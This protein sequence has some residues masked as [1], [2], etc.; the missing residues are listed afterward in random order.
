MSMRFSIIIPV[1]KVEKFLHQCVDSVLVQTFS[2]YEVILVDDGSP[3]GCPG[4]CDEYAVKFPQIRVIHKLNGGLSDAR[5]AGLDVAEG[6]YIIFLDSDDWWDDKYAL[7]KID[8]RI[9]LSGVEILIIGMKKYYHNDDKFGEIRTPRQYNAEISILSNA[10]ILQLYMHSNIF[11]ACAWDK[12]VRRSLIENDHQRFVKGQMSED[13]EWCAKLLMKN[14]K[15]GILEDAFYVYRQQVSTSI[16]ANVGL[17]NI[18]SILDIISRYSKL[19]T[20]VPLLHFMANQYVLLITNFMRLNKKDQKLLNDD[21]KRYWWLLKY[22]WYPY[23]KKVSRV[24]FL[25]YEIT[26]RLLRIYYKQRHRL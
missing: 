7:K 23:T 9:K 22:N 21:V 8:D 16:T 4:I 2:D 5:N 15:I 14:S 10:Q 3:D 20:S 24:K 19:E 26:K 6:E 17:Q 18:Y 12:I 11:V 1:Y 25:G 13:I